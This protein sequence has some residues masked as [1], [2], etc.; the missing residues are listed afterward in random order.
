MKCK[1]PACSSLAPSQ[2]SQCL[3]RVKGILSEKL[4]AEVRI[5]EEVGMNSDFANRERIVRYS[6]RT[7]S[8]RV[9]PPLI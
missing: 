3:S 8:C 2:V 5:F 7:L 6:A 4:T 9:G 1:R